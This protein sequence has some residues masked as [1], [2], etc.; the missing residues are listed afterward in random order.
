MSKEKTYSPLEQQMANMYVNLIT[1]GL[2]ELGGVPARL[3]PL[4]ESMLPKQK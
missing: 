3:R 1:T 2:K 4:V